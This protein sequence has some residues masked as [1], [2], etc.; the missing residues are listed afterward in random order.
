MYVYQWTLCERGTDSNKLIYEVCV[1]IEA[2]ARISHEF[3]IRN[4]K[5]KLIAFVILL[6]EIRTAKDPTNRMEEF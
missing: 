5:T 2:Y 4:V 3:E 6:D 1:R